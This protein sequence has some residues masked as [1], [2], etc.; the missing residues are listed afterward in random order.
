MS[1][2]DYKK[3]ILNA[4]LK[5]KEQG[6]LSENLTRHRPARIRNECLT[7]IDKWYLDEDAEM[8]SFFF[9]VNDNKEGF[10]REIRKFDIDKFRPLNN[11]LHNNAIGTDEKNIELLAWL[12]GFQPRPYRKFS[13]NPGKEIT[14]DPRKGKPKDPGPGPRPVKRT[15][16]L[17]SMALFAGTGIY[18]GLQKYPK[19]QKCM[20]W[21]GAR[22][23]PISCDKKIE[24]VVILALDTAKV[25]H[26]E[27]ITRPDTLTAASLK[28]V[29]YSKIDN[30]V[31]FYTSA[32]T[33]PVHM[34]R[35]LRP[36]SMYIL[37]RYGGKHP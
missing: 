22:Y 1:F 20:Y 6:N 36:L 27:R 15:A 11:F 25:K 30:K 24:D 4:Y 33:H 2:G 10:E 37:D 18:W 21:A 23:E 9:G 16:V 5:R 32:G 13:A 29:W 14:F 17:L 12:I 26:F 31:E 35:R 34:E 28:K 3:A 19:D 8:L 7:I